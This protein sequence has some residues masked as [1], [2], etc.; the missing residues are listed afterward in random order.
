MKKI[1]FVCT[2]N[3]CRSQMA[4]GFARHYANGRFEVRSA[5]IFPTGIHPMT[6]ETMR[7]VGVDISG[8]GSTILSPSLMEWADYLVTLCVSARE[9]KPPAPSHLV[10]IH[11]DIENPDILYTS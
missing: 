10:D 8:H 5:G 9:R 4:E 6:I 2:G 11:W 7:E 1:L 3:S